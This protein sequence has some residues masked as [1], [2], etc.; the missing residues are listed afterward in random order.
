[1]LNSFN[2]LE[3]STPQSLGLTSQ[4]RELVSILDELQ[5]V[6]VTG[7]SNNTDSTGLT[8]YFCSGTVFNLSN[9]VLSDAEIKVLEKGLDY[10]PIQNK[11]NELELSND[12]NEF[13]RRMRRKWYFRN[14]V[15]PNFREVPAFRP[16]FLRN[17]PKDTLI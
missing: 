7:P 17:P 13:G 1:M 10:A 12:F 2:S 5:N 14:E 9:R 11:I 4:D 16:K 15:T 3:N 8:G 6:S